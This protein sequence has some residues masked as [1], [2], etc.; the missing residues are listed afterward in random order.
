MHHSGW[1]HA[2][3]TPVFMRYVTSAWLPSCILHVTSTAYGNFSYYLQ[4]LFWRSQ[5]DK[6]WTTQRWMAM[7]SSTKAE[8]AFDLFLNA[9][10]VYALLCLNCKCCFRQRFCLFSLLY[11]GLELW[12][13]VR[14]L[15]QKAASK[16]QLHF[17]K[18]ILY[19]EKNINMYYEFHI[20]HEYIY[21]LKY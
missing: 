15:K 1:R 10:L 12:V 11:V 8:T 20:T 19:F 6:S 9:R 3:K 4:V 21:E 13:R 18:T 5:T 2:Q 14:I 7:L 17:I 16:F